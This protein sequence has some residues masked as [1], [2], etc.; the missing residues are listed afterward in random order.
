MTTGGASVTVSHET[1][2]VLGSAV[3]VARVHGD[4]APVVLCGGLGSSWHDWVDVLTLLGDA[5]C[6]AFALDRPGF[7]DSEPRPGD[8][9]TV[10]G[11]ARRIVAVLDALGLTRP[12]VLVGHSM[13]G[14]YV[15]GAA[16]LEPDRVGGLVLLDS[17]VEK[18]PGALIPRR[19]RMPAA[20]ALA[21]TSSA[22][23][24]Q[25]LGADA[26]RHL[27]VRAVPPDGYPPERIDELRRLYREPAYLEAATVEYFAYADLAVELNRLRRATPR[28]D[29][30]VVV[31]AA[32]T[33]H[34]TP[35]GA[36]WIRK[37]RRLAS[38]L[39]GRFVVV[40]PSHHHVMIDQP[41]VVVRTVDAVLR[42][43][44]GRA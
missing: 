38:Y 21:R 35:W 25:A 10:A 26:V 33:S 5:G 16:R 36:R 29:V 24:L 32:H 31:A 19:L 18:S 39:G 37:Q 30:P 28:P 44:S 9:P 41:A 4:S 8:V 40:S 23:G 34:R 1:V 27:V 22:V 43:A 42:D 7:G 3:H 11:E 17:S 2:T 15:E 20:R 14:F 6:S 13:A 12:A